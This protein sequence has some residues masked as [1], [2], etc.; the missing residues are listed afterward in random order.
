MLKIHQMSRLY[1]PPHL[2]I[3]HHYTHQSLNNVNDEIYGIYGI[4]AHNIACPLARLKKV[5]MPVEQ[6]GFLLSMPDWA[7]GIYYRPE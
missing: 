6:L 4:Y 1:K 7:E 2:N 3:L 5:L